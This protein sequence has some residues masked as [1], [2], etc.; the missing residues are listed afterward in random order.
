MELNPRFLFKA[1]LVLLGA[2]FWPVPPKDNGKDTTDTNYIITIIEKLLSYQRK[3]P[4]TTLHDGRIIAIE[5]ELYIYIYI[6][7]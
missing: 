4:N 7:T 3:V 1:D 6:T 2:G 5:N